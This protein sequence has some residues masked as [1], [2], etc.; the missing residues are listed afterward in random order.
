MGRRRVD[1]GVGW[2]AWALWE[3]AEVGH[4]DEIARQWEIS[5]PL[6]T[7]GYFLGVMGRALLATYAL[8]FLIVGT[9]MAGTGEADLLLPLAAMLGLATAGIGVLMVAIA[10]VA[11][12]NR[13]RVRFTIDGN[14]I[15]CETLGR[16]VR[17]AGRLGAA[18]GAL[19][20]SATAAGAGL[21]AVSHQEV[22]LP[23]SGAFR[24]VPGKRRGLIRLTNRWRTRLVLF[25]RPEDHD[26][27]LLL[28]HQG[29]ARHGSAGRLAT[30]SPLPRLL[31]RTG[32]VALAVVPLLMVRDLVDPG[33]FPVILMLCFALATVWLVPLFGWVML[34]VAAYEVGA[35]FVGLLAV[36]QSTL[37][38][39]REYRLV[40]V[41]SAEDRVVL[42]LAAAGLGYLAWLAIAHLRG[43]MA[44][45]LMADEDA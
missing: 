11:F 45:V 27:I 40:E 12:G 17:R 13:W 23:W 33:L 3:D 21:L 18:A 16:A 4:E 8:A 15:T 2:G 19:G 44:S 10:L 43:R 34:A 41:L 39:G 9:I 37:F 36:H 31:G 6:V 25:C 26:E 20:G 42:A 35:I 32:A 28:I 30:R 14:G 22:T 29:I 1:P 24:V 38:P 5:V 7:G